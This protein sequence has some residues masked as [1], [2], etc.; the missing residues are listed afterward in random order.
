MKLNQECIII[1]S[2]GVTTVFRGNWNW[3]LATV[4]ETLAIEVER[5]GRFYATEMNE[6]NFYGDGI[7]Y[8]VSDRFELVL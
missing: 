4:Y 6:I 3:H 8:K 2:V 1:I 5:Q 7:H